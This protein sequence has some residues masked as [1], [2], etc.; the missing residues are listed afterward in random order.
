M[1]YAKIKTTNYK[2]C[3]E[4]LHTAQKDKANTSKSIS[5]ITTAEMDQQKVT[6]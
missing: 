3:P 2:K 5:N 4:Q 1:P 6:N